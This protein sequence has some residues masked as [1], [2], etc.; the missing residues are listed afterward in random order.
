MA[1]IMQN[2]Q[3]TVSQLSLCVCVCTRNLTKYKSPLCPRY[4]W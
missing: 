1:A 3:Q 2:A 4:L